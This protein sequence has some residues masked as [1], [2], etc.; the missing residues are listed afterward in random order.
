[1]DSPTSGTSKSTTMDLLI[2]IMDSNDNAPELNEVPE[3]QISENAGIGDVVVMIQA[4][5]ADEGV[6]A[7]VSYSIISGSLP[8]EI[9]SI[10]GE[11][12]VQQSLDLESGNH[13]PDFK[14]TLT[15]EARDGGVPSLASS[16]LVVIQIIGINEF[17][18]TFDKQTDVISV[19]EN[20]TKSTVVYTPAVTD[21][22]QSTDGDLE[23]TLTDKDGEDY[24]SINSSTGEVSVAKQLDYI[25][26]PHGIN[27]TITAIDKPV[28]P[29]TAR[30]ASMDLTVNV[31]YVGNTAPIFPESLDISVDED[32]GVDDVISTID[33]MDANPGPNGEV[34]F[35]I[36]NGNSLGH[37]RIDENSG[38]VILNKS[39]DLETP[40]AILSHTL[41]IRATDRGT[42]PLS[43]TKTMTITVL[44][45]NEFTPQFDV[46]IDT[47]TVGEEA[48][49]S[50][51]VYQARASDQDY[52]SDGEVMYS[53]AS[54][55]EAGYF[56]IDR[57]N[58]T[59]NTVTLLDREAHPNG[60][61]LVLL[62]EDRA[63][64]GLKRNSTMSLHVN[65][66]DFNDNKPFFIGSITPQDVSEMAEVDHNIVR[67]Q[68]SDA[69]LGENAEIVYSITQGNEL[70]YFDIDSNNGQIK[71]SQSLDLD[72]D[73]QTHSADLKY[74]LTIEAQDKG[75]PTQ[76]N[77]TT[78]EITIISENE[79]A[80]VFADS[81]DTIEV[82]EDTSELTDI[83]TASA[84]DNDFG[85]EGQIIY[86]I[87]SE[88]HQGYFAIDSG[89]GKV[90][91]AKSLD[92]EAIP[93]GIS[94][95]IQAADQPTIGSPK[96]ATM[97]LEIVITDV[98]DEEPVF[99]P[100]S[101]QE[102]SEEAPVDST[103][104]Q[105]QATD[106]D[107]GDNAKITYSITGGN[108]LG[109]FDINSETGDVRVA[110]S[111]DL[112]TVTHAAGLSY[113]LTITA[114]DSGQPPRSTSASLSITITS[115]NEFAPVFEQAVAYIIAAHNTPVSD[116]VYE[117]QATDQDFGAD[118]ELRYTMSSSNND[119]YFTIDESNGQIS[120]A[121][122]LNFTAVSNGVNITITATDQAIQD[123]K[124]D[125]MQLNIEVKY[126]DNTA[127]V[128][129]EDIPSDVS[130]KE[131]STVGTVVVSVT[132]TDTNP[133]S[134]GELEYSILS[135]NE[136]GFFEIN[137]DSGDLTVNQN[138]DLET[139]SHAPNARYSLT[140]Q[141][142]DHGTP[143]LSAT[144]VVNIQVSPVNE[145]T[146][147]ILAISPTTLSEDT[148]VRTLVVKV[149]GSDQDYG[150]DG[151]LTY[152]ITSGN[153][154]GHFN[155]NQTTGKNFIRLFQILLLEIWW[156]CY[157]LRD[158]GT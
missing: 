6:N 27:L 21:G 11:I 38:D 94:L 137:A 91:V 13:S 109:F 124:T 133:G 31:I 16:I 15:V 4:T 93:E 143:P 96:T 9:D 51:K 46:T 63:A 112:E 70:G 72:A 150:D 43:S 87:I 2:Q 149:T 132:A 76:S 157:P 10:T 17:N 78:V 116:V 108:S 40:D 113:T 34:W 1:M 35:K 28:D 57:N 139:Q 89:S 111:L 3:Q 153:E 37:F 33:I 130:I 118:G 44:S 128:F 105:V 92:R 73:S 60:I 123:P 74:I 156:H 49:V 83:Y 119:G 39:L 155:I 50:T 146:P 56:E 5:D 71:V 20:T 42:P 131:N 79:F 106:Q 54:G 77:T 98:N 102:V 142:R 24:F 90:S 14:Y 84:T 8:F 110:K 75:T 66:T 97:D 29:S 26:T 7:A 30:N 88:S 125:S 68:A 65:I 144:K 135:G 136:F 101:A 48:T 59:V 64:E 41:T 122:E 120:V 22:D 107:L 32:L 45:V 47:T 36:E 85:N 141:A 81:N 23:F 55:N 154:E 151:R 121:K 99:E 152:T 53:I 100:I 138:L 19:Q 104:I 80:P 12:K 52:G 145:F 140:I 117:A 62:V 127:P 147:S 148:R 126:V 115:V 18:P 134:N 58:G 95:T 103:V 129:S 61:D 86:S 82:S 158:L 69:D 114:T 67:V 25:A